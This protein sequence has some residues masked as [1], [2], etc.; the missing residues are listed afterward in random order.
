MVATT[1]VPL[2]P[3]SQAGLLAYY[4]TL[5]NFQ[6]VPR[7]DFRA[8][9]EEIDK[10]YQRELDQSEEHARA[11]AAN[12]AGN[13]TRFQNMTVP[14]V[15]PQVETAVTYQTSVF[16]TGHPIFGVVSSPEY[17]DEAKQ[18][19]TK[20]EADA[21]RGGWTQELIKFFRDGFKYNFAPL[22]V[23]WENETTYSVDTDVTK[24]IKQG[25]AKEVIYSGNALKRLDPY[26]TFIDTRVPAHEL[27]KK[28]EFGGYTEPVSRIQLKREIASLEGVIIGNI[29]AAFESPSVGSGS[30]H[31]GAMN[32]YKPNINNE[33]NTDDLAKGETNWMAYA[34]ISDQEKQTIQYKDS[35]ERTVLYCRIMPV[36]FGIKTSAEKTPQVH[37]LVIINH[38]VIIHAEKLTNAH[39]YIP[40][41]IGQPSADGLDYQTKSLATNGAPFQALASTYMNSIIASRRR[42]ISDR[43]LYDPSRITSAVINSDNPSAKMPVRPAAYGKN[44]SDAVY[45]FPYR[46]DQAAG[47]MQQIQTIMGLAN[48]L[49]GQNQ[50]SQGQ[51]VKGNKTLSEYEDVMGN[52]NGRDQMVSILLEVQIFTPLKH[53]LKLN[54]LQFQGPE[55]IY[56][57]D[58]QKLIEIDPV[59]LRKAVLEFKVTDGL[60]PASKILNTESLAVALQVLGSTPQ[61]AG[62]YNLTQVFS[63]LM[64]AQGTDLTAFEK[65]AE[66]QAYEQAVN[67]WQQLTAL[68]MEKNTPQLTAQLGPMPTPEQFGYNPSKNKPAPAEAEGQSQPTQTLGE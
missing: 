63:Y 43:V 15:M 7:E 17:M 68:A 55:S 65:S 37:K 27:Y 24:S 41:L 26:N 33:V 21:K 47:S 45:Q 28:G 6:N 49:S 62:G 13:P 34:G 29:K 30:V 36:E 4:K 44:L 20:F 61:L 8:R 16:L 50:A 40:I 48:Q 9:F 2:S 58:E 46:E 59:A 31:A 53:I 25:V 11:K 56:N 39:G 66:Q 52:A 32:Y 1:V 22:E 38:S 3:K 12:K 14:I 10:T 19:E 35:Y 51:F 60:T 23:T 64:K 54:T 42:A 5:Q 18:L 57:R 67:Q